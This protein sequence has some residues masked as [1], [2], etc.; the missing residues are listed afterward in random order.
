MTY[1]EIEARVVADLNRTDLTAS[2]QGWVNEAYQELINRRVWT[3]MGATTEAN[4]VVDGYRYELPSDFSD[5]TTMVLSDGL[6]S[7]Q[8]P[9]ITVEAYDKRYPAVATD[10]GGRPQVYTIRH[11]INPAGTHY[12]EINVYPKAD[13]TTYTFRLFYTVL[14][15]NLSGALVPVIPTPFHQIL[16]FAGLETGFARLREYDAAAYW[17]KKKEL[18]Y[19]AMEEYDTK[20]PSNPIMRP[21]TTT[22]TLPG[23]YWNRYTVRSV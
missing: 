16:V 20:F 11:G 18:T 2:V 22:Q 5:S 3:W 17:M 15:T 21:F 23:D 10:V 1:A 12:D 9:Y 14:V 19:K 7:D 6:I 13:A 4:T 8:M